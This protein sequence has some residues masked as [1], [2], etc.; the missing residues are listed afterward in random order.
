[1]P[2]EERAPEDEVGGRGQAGPGGRKG[3]Q[4]RGEQCGGAVAEEGEAT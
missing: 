2:P 3:S 4:R 1:M